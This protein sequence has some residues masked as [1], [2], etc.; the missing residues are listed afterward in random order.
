MSEERS[1]RINKVLRE[2]NISLDRAV[3]YLKEKGIAIDS[4]PNAKIS[5][6]EYGILQGGFAG[7][8]GNKAA[9]IELGE[10]KRKEKEALRIERERE[11]EAKRIQ[12]EERRNQEVIKAKAVMSG[13]KQVGTI[14]LNPKKPAAPAPAPAPSDSKPEEKP[15]AAQSA[16]VEPQPAPA[17]AAEAPAAEPAQTPGTPAEKPTEEFATQYKKLSGTTLTGQTIDLSQFEKPK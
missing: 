3:E 10:E 8:K 6:R 12:D 16:P 9:S 13:P 4:N 1:I 7:D 5:D 11:I 15:V 2:F 17:P 14:D